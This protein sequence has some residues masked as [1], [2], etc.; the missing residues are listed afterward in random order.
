VQIVSD[1][2]MDLEPEQMA[3]IVVHLAPLTFTLDGKSYRSG[4]D[5]QPAEF[6]KLIASTPSYPSTSQ[7][8]PG[9]FAEIYRRLAVTDPDILSI[10]ISSGLSGTLNAAK[11]GA[12]LVPEAHV[13]FFDSKTL[14]AAEGWQVEAAARAAK[15]G[16]EM[17][18]V[19][20]LL[21]RVRSATEIL[22]TLATLRYLVHGGRIGHIKGLLAQVLDLKPV[23]GVEKVGGTY[24]QRGQART[25]KRSIA[26]IAQL[27]GEKHPSGSALRV[28]VCHGDNPEGAAQLVELLNERYRCTWL[29]T[30]PIAPVLGAHTG[31]GLVG[32]VYAPQAEFSDI[33][34]G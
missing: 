16:W 26:L 34:T 3:G 28:Q 24:I 4:V 8:A 21:R 18:R 11:A 32:L 30:G 17:P 12:A 27:V 10:H 22:Y 23:I 9:D 31:A 7:P 5:I 14:S 15:A 6:Y 20:D 29:P 19:M 2:A 13:T 1:R 25:L 33:P